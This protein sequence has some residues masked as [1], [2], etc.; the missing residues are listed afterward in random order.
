MLQRTLLAEDIAYDRL[1]KMKKPFMV[2]N[3]NVDWSFRPS[4]TSRMRPWS[5]R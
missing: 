1:D 4:T 5:F 3:E 2:I